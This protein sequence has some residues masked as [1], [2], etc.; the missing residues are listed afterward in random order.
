MNATTLVELSALQITEVDV[1]GNLL[2]QIKDLTDEADKIKDSIKDAATLPNGS[3]VHEGALFQATV[4]E[5]NRSTINW[6][7]IVAAK[8]GVDFNAK[9]KPETLWSKV[10]IKIGFDPVA[11]LPKA[12]ADNTKTTAVFSVKVTSR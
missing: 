5:A 7:N 11:E 10:A 6:L 3:K 2:A 1:L 12:I 9:D 4:V 8:L